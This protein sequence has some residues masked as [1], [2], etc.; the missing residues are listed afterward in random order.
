MGF[1]RT[2][3][4]WRKFVSFD[5][6][7]F[8]SSGLKRIGRRLSGGSNNN[9]SSKKQQQQQHTENT[10]QQRVASESALESAH[11]SGT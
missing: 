6:V 9:N 8:A 1:E 11:A 3:V 5:V 7:D 2:A 4:A 10:I